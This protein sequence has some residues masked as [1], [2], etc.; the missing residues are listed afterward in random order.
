MH[1]GFPTH[2]RRH[3]RTKSLQGQ[4][5]RFIRIFFVCDAKEGQI[6]VYVNLS[7]KI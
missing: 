4:Q 6:T 5:N 3:T 1:V 7:C 2:T